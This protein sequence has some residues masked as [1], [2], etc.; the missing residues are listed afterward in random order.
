MRLQSAVAQ[1]SAEIRL[2]I[3]PAE[4]VFFV[5]P[6]LYG[7]MTGEINHSYEGGL[8]AEFIQNRTF[9]TTWEAS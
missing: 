8:Y 1:Q 2:E 9:Y 7:L 5:S 6:M 3:H 4:I